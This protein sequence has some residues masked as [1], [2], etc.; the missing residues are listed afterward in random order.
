MQCAACMSRGQRRMSRTVYIGGAVLASSVYTMISAWRAVQP[1]NR[2]TRRRSLSGLHANWVV[3]RHQLKLL[4]PANRVETCFTIDVKAGTHYPWSRFVCTGLKVSAADRTAGEVLC[5]CGTVYC[6]LCATIL[7]ALAMNTGYT[8]AR[9]VKSRCCY[10]RFCLDH[11]AA[12]F[13][14]QIRLAE[15]FPAD[16]RYPAE[17]YETNE[18]RWNK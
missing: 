7:V 12:N 5:Y 17:F 15:K 3:S 10:R 13:L 4:I 1:L 8:L 9:V 14:V 16:I 2:I 18:I 11:S 6:L